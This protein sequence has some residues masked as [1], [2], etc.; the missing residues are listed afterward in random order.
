MRSPMFGNSVC[1]YVFK[2]VWEFRLVLV[3]APA[4]NPSLAAC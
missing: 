2:T 1:I 3:R 4:R